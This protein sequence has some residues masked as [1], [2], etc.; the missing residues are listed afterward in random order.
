M[1]KVHAK[2]RR[3]SAKDFPAMLEINRNDG[4]DYVAKMNIEW[5]KKAQRG[6]DAFFIAEHKGKALGFCSVQPNYTYGSRLRFLSVLK[7][8]QH[9]GIGAALME[10]AEEHA[11]GNGKKK[12]FLY[13]NQKNFDAIRFYS[14]HKFYVTGIFL[15]KYG[16]GGNALLMAKDLGEGEK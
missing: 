14:K 9:K 8:F 5:L 11:R 4:F 15:E 1:V 2:I 16:K 6:K 10:K 7:K 13:V 3:A 12:L